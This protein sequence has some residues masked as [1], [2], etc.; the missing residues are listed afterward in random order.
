MVATSAQALPGMT[1]CI[2]MTEQQQA[3]KG[4]ISLAEHKRAI[5]E[6]KLAAV[7]VQQGEES[8]I[9]SAINSLRSIGAT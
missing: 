2:R 8:D 6:I 5:A 3:P 1:W 4:Y 7:M 9:Q